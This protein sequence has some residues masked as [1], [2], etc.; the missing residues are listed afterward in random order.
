MRRELQ[1][2]LK[3]FERKLGKEGKERIRQVKA[4]R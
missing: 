3:Q 2:S 1:E 4:L